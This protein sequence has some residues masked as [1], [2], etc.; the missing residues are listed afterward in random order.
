MKSVQN[1]YFFLIISK[2][3]EM[4]K[5]EGETLIKGKL[6]K[7]KSFYDDLFSKKKIDESLA[8]FFTQ[9]LDKQINKAEQDFL[10]QDFSLE[11]VLTAIKSFDSSKTPGNDGLP[12]E[13]YKCFWEILKE[14]FLDIIGRASKDFVLPES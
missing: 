9:N 3:Q 2:K 7:V 5:I 10:A 4:R 1:I 13:F 8:D 11:E 12:V 14:D 6:D